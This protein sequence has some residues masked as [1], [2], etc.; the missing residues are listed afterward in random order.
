[1]V[2]LKDAA[3]VGRNQNHLRKNR[4]NERQYLFDAA[5][6]AD[7]SQEKVYDKTTRPLVEAVL[8]GY[9]ACVF[10]YGATGAGKTYTMVG[11]RDN[12]GCMVRALNDIFRATDS[13]EDNVFKVRLSYFGLDSNL[14]YTVL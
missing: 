2:V 8:E 11:T 14:Q 1:M 12:P 10:A 6:G 3:S 7:S 5:F 9:N 4:S 13:N